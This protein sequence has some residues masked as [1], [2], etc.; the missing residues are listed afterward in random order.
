MLA[1]VRLHWRLAIGNWREKIAEHHLFARHGD[2]C[3]C[4]I[5]ANLEHFKL[6]N[7]LDVG[8]Y[9]SVLLFVNAFNVS[10]RANDLEGLAFFN[11]LRRTR[12]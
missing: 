7:V 2:L 10:A 4:R 8:S 1:S 12:I 3:R 9:K 5:L 6:T 11:T